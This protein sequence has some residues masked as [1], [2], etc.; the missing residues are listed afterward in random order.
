MY[1]GLKCKIRRN[2]L[3]H[4]ASPQ[5]TY[6]CRISY[7]KGCELGDDRGSVSVAVSGIAVYELNQ[8]LVGRN[9]VALLGAATDDCRQKFTHL[10]R[11]LRI[12]RAVA[13]SDCVGQ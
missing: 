6:S 1:I 5:F 11:P 8:K 3:Q 2:V 4:H 10:A 13:G 7:L 12:V 9:L